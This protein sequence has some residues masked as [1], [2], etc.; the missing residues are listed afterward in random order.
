M[1]ITVAVLRRGLEALKRAPVAGPDY[2]G[3][4]PDGTWLDPWTYQYTRLPGRW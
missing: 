3:P 4:G 2:D 1:R